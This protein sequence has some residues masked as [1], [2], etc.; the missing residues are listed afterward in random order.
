MFYPKVTCIIGHDFGAGLCC[1][2]NLQSLHCGVLH[3]IFSSVMATTIYI[4]NEEHT[5]ERISASHIQQIVAVLHHQGLCT[6]DN[7]FEETTARSIR[8]HR[9]ATSSERLFGLTQCCE[10]PLRIGP[11]LA[12]VAAL[13]MG[14]RAGWQS[15]VQPP[16]TSPL[17]ILS[18]GIVLRAATLHWE[19][20]K[21]QEHVQCLEPGSVVL[22]DISKSQPNVI[23]RED[24]ISGSSDSHQSL[25]YP[26]WIQTLVGMRNFRCLQCGVFNLNAETHIERCVRNIM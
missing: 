14:A 17:S 4:S 8:V 2:G 23:P 19:Q 6:L 5:Q 25:E 10:S 24:P 11:L 22:W 16:S 1:C 21:S 3:Y 20:G 15:R 7:V 12:Q 9:M 13:R 18:I 26:V